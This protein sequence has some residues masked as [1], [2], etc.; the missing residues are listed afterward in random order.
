MTREEL[1][2]EAE[3]FAYNLFGVP[4]LAI[5]LRMKPEDVQLAIAD[6]DSDLGQAIQRGWLM[7]EAELNEVTLKLAMQGSTPALIEALRMQRS[8]ER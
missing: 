7:R 8:I 1:C 6:P 3:Q 4:K 2:K 5:V